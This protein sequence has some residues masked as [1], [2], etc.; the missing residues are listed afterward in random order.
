[1]QKARIGNR[2][3]GLFEASC[4]VTAA[5]FRAPL[6]WFV[7]SRVFGLREEVDLLGNDLTAIASLARVIG[8]PG[9][10][11]PSGDHDHR[12]LGDVL[13]DAFADA[14]EAGEPTCPQ[15]TVRRKPKRR[16]THLYIRAAE[17][18]ASLS[19]GTPSWPKPLTTSVTFAHCASTIR[20]R[21]KAPPRCPTLRFTGT[22]VPDTF[23]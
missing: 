22:A 23:A 8:P 20:I 11:D 5:L 10:M 13:G 14:V 12:A 2:Q 6:L 16:C 18:F 3:S 19:A 1:M 21:E 4:P 15:D 9:I 7:R 17:V